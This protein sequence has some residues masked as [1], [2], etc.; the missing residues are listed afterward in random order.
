MADALCVIGFISTQSSW[1][2]AFAPV[3]LPYLG[4]ACKRLKLGRLMGLTSKE[5]G[6][7]WYTR[8]ITQQVYL[9]SETTFGT[10]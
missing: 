7:E 4:T 2:P 10:T 3:S 6:T 5:Q 8:T 9:G 1:S